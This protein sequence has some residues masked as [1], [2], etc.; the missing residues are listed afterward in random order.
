MKKRVLLVNGLH[1]L[2]GAERFA[3]ILLRHLDRRKFELALCVLKRDHREYELPSDVELFSLDHGLADFEAIMLE[4]NGHFYPSD[5]SPSLRRKM[6]IRFSR[7]LPKGRS[8]R[9][10]AR[11]LDTWRPDVVVSLLDFLT[12]MVGLALGQSKVTPRWIARTGNNPVY[13][14]RGIKGW[15]RQKQFVRVYLRADLRVAN[16]SGLAERLRSLYPE[17]SDSVHHIPN[18][19]D[20]EYLQSQC[21]EEPTITRTPGRALLVSLARYSPQKRYDTLLDGMKLLSRER[22]DFELWLC[23]SGKMEAEIRAMIEERELHAQVKV[24]GHQANPFPI[25]RQAD[26]VLS[27][28]EFEGLPNSLIEAQALGIPVIAADC[29]FGPSDI[30]EHGK[31]GYLIPVGDSQGLASHIMR[32]LDDPRGRVEMAKA[33]TLRIESGFGLQRVLPLWETALAGVSRHG[34]NSFR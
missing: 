34:R 24:L 26:I 8:V 32:V 12:L 17:L 2:G 31:S 11:V 10:L 4:E 5:F 25:V 7:F 19:V 9:R 16:S 30:V 33:A 29:Q 20:M 3:S 6:E 15:I 27:T 13:S 21:M 1:G 23:G 14:F 28:S 18:P 22:K